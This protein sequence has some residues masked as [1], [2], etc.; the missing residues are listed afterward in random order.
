M[1]LGALSAG[2]ADTINASSTMPTGPDSQG[3]TYGLQADGNVIQCPPDQP[4]DASILMCSGSPCL[5]MIAT[6]DSTGSPV[7]SLPSGPLA[8]GQS[9]CPPPGQGVAYGSTPLGGGGG[10][11]FVMNN[12][13]LLI[14]AAVLVLLLLMNRGGR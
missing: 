9:V 3:R 1:F 4:Y 6:L 7:Y 5:P 12:N 14:G 11:G 10:G 13:T 8:P 2:A